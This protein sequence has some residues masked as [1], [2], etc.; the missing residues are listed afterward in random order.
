M[1]TAHVLLA[2]IGLPDAHAQH[3]AIVQLGVS[4][5]DLARC[6]DP[7][8]NPLCGIVTV[9]V[10]KADQVQGRRCNAFE[11][12]V[13]VYPGGE[14]LRQ[15]LLMHDPLESGL[16]DEVGPGNLR[17]PM[18]GK[19]LEVLVSEG[20]KVQRGAPM[21]ILE[22]MKMEHTIVAPADGIV[23]RI[24]YKQGDLIDEGVDLVE[25]EAD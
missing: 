15:A 3:V 17:S 8:E 22:A 24:S 5:V 12:G 10:A 21:I 13:L 20:E 9:S 6:V 7:F 2:S 4:Q 18:P 16:E 14:L 19:V 11:I 25:F 1:G 23:T